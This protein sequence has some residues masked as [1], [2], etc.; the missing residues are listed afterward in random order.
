M[1]RQL[2]HILELESIGHIVAYLNIGF[3]HL[4]Y[5]SLALTLNGLVEDTARLA[6]ITE[7]LITT[8]V[9]LLELTMNSGTHLVIEHE[10]LAR[11]HIDEDL[12]EF[13]GC[14]VFEMDGLREATLQTRVG[15]DE[16]VHLVGIASHDTDKLTTIVQQ[17]VDGL[18]AKGVLIIRL[19]RIGLVDKQHTTNGGVDKLVGL[20]SRLTREACHQLRTVGLNEL[21]AREDAQRLEDIG[22]DTCHSGLTCTRITSEDIVL[23]LEGVGLATLDLQR[24]EG[25]QTG[26]L[27]LHG[28]QTDHTIELLQAL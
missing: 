16:V 23:A 9:K 25:S 17:G 11:S 27:F 8:Q 2:V 7:V 4:T 15:V 28:F 18:I 5:Q 14:I 6:G 22:H 21:S 20:D 13:V 26:N 24:E 3:A 12:R 19:Q 1:H 10:F